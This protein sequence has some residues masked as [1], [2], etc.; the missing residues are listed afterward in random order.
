MTKYIHV[1]MYA[2]SGGNTNAQ[3][4]ATLEGP[5]GGLG[6]SWNQHNTTSG[7]GLLDA[8]GAVTSAQ[9]VRAVEVGALTPTVS[10]EEDIPLF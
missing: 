6:E 5:A 8:T 9:A 7:S 3:D 4:P 2:S 10:M 1:N